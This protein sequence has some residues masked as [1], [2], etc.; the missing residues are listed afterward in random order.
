MTTQ[1]TPEPHPTSRSGARSIAINLLVL[2]VTVVLLL[3]VIELTLRITDFR[4]VLTPS[5]I[6]FG[7]P[8][9]LM[10]EMGFEEDDDLFWVP[11]GYWQKI[12]MLTEQRPPLLLLGDSC[13][14]LGRYDERL[15]E[16]TQRTRGA[17]LHFGNLAV[18]GW[19]SY[20]GRRQMER[21]VPALQPKVV[22][23]YFGWNDHWIGFGLEDRTVAQVKQIFS[24]RWSHLR[25]VQLLT[26]AT[27]AYRAGDT[28]FP[29]RVSLA[30]FEDNMITMVTKAQEI[31]AIPVVITAAS[32]HV[33]GKEPKSL[34]RRWLRNLDDL[35]PLHQSYVEVQR[36]V[37][38][39]T[40][41]VL[42]DLEAELATLDAE[43]RK[44]L[45]MRDGI[46]FRK[47]GQ[48]KVAELLDQCFEREQLWPVILEP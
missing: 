8:D 18:V 31:G 35:V 32:N 40:G 4:F 36:R 37:A 20:Q 42:C 3:G 39:N 25:T 15:A 43:T 21:D 46:H 23:I 48:R 41:A 1:K 12:E 29:N 27:V 14:H 2:T 6:E 47:K 44:E 9:P 38:Q 30:D 45:F 19:S 24:S 7:R 33:R 34:K 22:T 16:L 10:L 17:P 13:T 28:D 11:K 5:D 26:K